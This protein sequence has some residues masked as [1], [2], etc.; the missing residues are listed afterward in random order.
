MLPDDQR[1][2]PNEPKRKNWA[3]FICVIAL[4]ICFVSY[5]MYSSGR[6]VMLYPLLISIIV[7]VA[8]GYVALA[9]SDSSG[10]Q[11]TFASLSATPAALMV[12]LALIGGI[13][14]ICLIAASLR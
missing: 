14:F 1:E 7:A 8:A 10:W 2:K 12:I 5:E 13:G 11:A 4:L 3:G 6:D 9:T